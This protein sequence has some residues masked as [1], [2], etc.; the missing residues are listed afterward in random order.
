MREI[1]IDFTDE[2]ND[3]EFEVTRDKRHGVEGF[4]V[5][6]RVFNG[7]TEQGNKVYMWDSRYQFYTTLDQVLNAIETRDFQQGKKDF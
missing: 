4:R 7:Q 6:R 3:E 2:D 1:I 5:I